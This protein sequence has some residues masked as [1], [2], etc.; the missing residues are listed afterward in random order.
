MV[1][2]Y[3]TDLIEAKWESRARNEALER[4]T[5]RHKALNVSARP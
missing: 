5:T 3:S 4:G 1:K 2:W